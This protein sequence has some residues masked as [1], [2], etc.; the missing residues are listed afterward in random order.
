MG[1]EGVSK[2]RRCEVELIIHGLHWINR[3][4]LLIG[5]YFNLIRVQ[6]LQT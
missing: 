1:M 3:L 2:Y 4:E 6:Y 5:N